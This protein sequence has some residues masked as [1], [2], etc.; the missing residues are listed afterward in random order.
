MRVHKAEMLAFVLAFP[1]TLR[2]LGPPHS[3]IFLK[4]FPADLQR[5]PPPSCASPLPSPPL[6]IHPATM[7]LWYVCL[8]YREVPNPL[9]FKARKH[10]MHIYFDIACVHIKISI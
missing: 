3:W 9:N 10:C 6:N 4:Q 5:S 8:T 1:P 2:R 7:L